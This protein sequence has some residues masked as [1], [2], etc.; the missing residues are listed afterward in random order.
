MTTDLLQ[1]ASNA[2]SADANRLATYGREMGLHGALTLSSL[3]ES[4]R[5]LRS[6]N[7]QDN[8]ARR[9]EMRRAGD[10]AASAAREQV[11]TL[12]YVSLERLRSMTLQD[13]VEL[14][15]HAGD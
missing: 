14:C 4:H 11:L 6:L 12:E 8:E 5:H 15:Q 2:T 3:I 1:S 13:I 7:L 10:F 9:A